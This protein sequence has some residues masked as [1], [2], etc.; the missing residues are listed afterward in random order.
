[1]E[2]ATSFTLAQLLP[3]IAPLYTRIGAPLHPILHTCRY[4]CWL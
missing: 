2:S 3:P 4:S 1:M